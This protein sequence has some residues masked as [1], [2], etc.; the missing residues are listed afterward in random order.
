MEIENSLTRCLRM[1]GLVFFCWLAF[2]RHSNSFLVSKAIANVANYQKSS[3]A[4]NFDMIVFSEKSAKLEGVANEI[5]R[6]THPMKVVKLCRNTVWDYKLHQSAI[7]LLNDIKELRN[8]NRKAVLANKY[9]KNIKFLVHCLNFSWNDLLKIDEADVKLKSILRYQTFLIDNVTDFTLETFVWF[10]RDTCFKPQLN[11]LNSL[12][13]T[14]FEWSSENFFPE[15]FKEFFGCELT[16]G[17]RHQAPAF[18]FEIVDGKISNIYGYNALIIQ[19]IAEHLNFTIN[20]NPY[21][22]HCQCFLNT[23]VENHYFMKSDSLHHI[24][25]GDIFVTEIYFET[26]STFLV[27]SGQLYTD[28]EKLFFPFDKETWISLLATYLIALF[29]IVFLKYSAQRARDFVF[30]E[31]VNDPTLN[32]FIHFFGGGQTVLPRR[33]FSRFIL[34]TFMM[35][36][37]IMR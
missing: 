36:C 35:F 9:A 13:K 19:N 18:G 14:T 16:I 28:F 10:S 12:D 17:V 6:R 1:K 37:L 24:S 5:L 32:L 11:L 33:N 3:G 4:N 25:I 8:I 23:S 30:G 7:L 15:K 2:L 29:V 22:E 20:Y 34:V 21:M 26:K 27:P 31:Q